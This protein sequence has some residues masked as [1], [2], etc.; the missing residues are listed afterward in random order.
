MKLNFKARHHM[1][2]LKSEMVRSI[3]NIKH[4][5]NNNNNNK[6]GLKCKLK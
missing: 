3:P 5:L 1:R 6:R 2:N 4:I